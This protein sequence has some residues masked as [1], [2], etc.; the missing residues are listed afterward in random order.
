M[1]LKDTLTILMP[2]KGRDKETKRL[3]RYF[4]DINLPFKILMADGSGNDL[5]GWINSE[6]Y[7][8]INL[9]YHNFGRDVNIHFFMTKMNKACSLITTPLTMMVD[10]DDFI[11]LNGIIK[12]IKFLEENN[13]YVSYRGNVSEPG[14]HPIYKKPSVLNE[15]IIER[16]E[17]SVNNR[18]AGWHDIV[19]TYTIK[20]FFEI[21]DKSETQDLQLVLTINTFWHMIY[22]KAHRCSNKPYYYHIPGNSLVQNKGI[23]SK[24]VKW[25]SYEKF[26][27]SMA[28]SISMVGNSIN[29]IDGTNL[30][31]AKKKFAK[32]ML[33]DV[34]K[35]NNKVM[36]DI[37]NLLELSK[38]YDEI[39]VDSINKTN[40]MIEFKLDEQIEDIEL[41][42]RKEENKIK[43]YL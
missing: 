27:S 33:G 13:D 15:T 20:K 40:E 8:N 6:N 17:N 31:E 5:S 2:L 11:S 37:N 38:K 24:Y 41:D 43:K 42:A 7:P 23:Y 21:L 3:L 18:N 1:K 26:N 12:G 36:P 14:G 39:S 29:I 4:N 16:I 10:N 9:E 30:E 35:M 28:L 19:R 25:A 34:C 22:G 32:I